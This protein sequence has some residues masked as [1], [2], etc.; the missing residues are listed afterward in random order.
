MDKSTDCGN[1]GSDN[2]EVEA[3]KQGRPEMLVDNIENGNGDQS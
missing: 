1:Y 3:W 2:D